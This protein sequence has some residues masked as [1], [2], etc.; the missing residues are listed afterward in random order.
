MFVKTMG[1]GWQSIIKKNYITG[2][3]T[4]VCGGNVQGNS[5]WSSGVS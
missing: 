2:R 1:S 4:C 3:E 5:G